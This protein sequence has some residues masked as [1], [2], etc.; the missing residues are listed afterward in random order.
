M[1]VT[2]VKGSL[3]ERL[4]RTSRWLVVSVILATSLAAITLFQH[5][6]H[7]LV[8]EI[9]IWQS[10]LITI[11]AGSLVAAVAG[12]FSLRRLGRLSELAEAERKERQQVEGELQQRAVEHRSLAAIVESSQDAII[13]EDLDGTVH[14][15]NKGAER[16][17]GWSAEE[18]IGRN[19]AL[20]VPDELAEELRDIP[21][22]VCQG[23][24][25]EPYRTVRK[26][27]DG[28]LVD[29]SLTVSPVKDE[30]GR[31]IGASAIARDITELRH[32]EDELRRSEEQHRTMVNAMLDTAADGIITMDENGAV[33]AINPAALRMFGYSAGEVLGRSINMLM[34]EP[35]RTEHDSYVRRHLETQEKRVVG[36]G[37][38]VLG[39]K[40]DGS[41]FPVELSL[42][43][44]RISERQ[45]FTGFVRDI[46]DRKRLE[47]EFLHAQ[48]ME[49]VGRLASGIAHDF[50]NML[51]GMIGCSRMAAK[52]LAPGSP[53]RE[54]VQEIG[55]EAERGVS[56]TKRL[57]TFSRKKGFSPEPIDVNAVLQQS[58]PMIRQLVGEDIE[59]E[60][61]LAPSLGPV[62]ADP[63][64]IEQVVMNLVVNARD[65]MPLGGTLRI[66]TSRFLGSGEEGPYVGRDGSH[67]TISVIDDGVGMDQETKLRAF[68][69]FFTTKEAGAGTGLGLATVYGIVKQLGGHVNLSSELG[70][71][72][73]FAI[74]LPRT[75]RAPLQVDDEVDSPAAKGGK[76]TVLVVEDE[77]LV[78]AS[79]RALLS[80]LGYRVLVAENGR[81]A[82][83][84][85]DDHEGRIDLLLSDIVMPG[86]SGPDLAR[87]IESRRP[88]VKTLYMS[89][90]PQEVLIEQGR[91][92]PGQPAIAKPFNEDTL[93]QKIRSVL[94]APRDIADADAQEPV[95]E[96]P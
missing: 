41:Q 22:K 62:L 16:L 35:Q 60:V 84:V 28:S 14:S 17:Y 74:H 81:N 20:I 24:R 89:A 52:N 66:E 78:R 86:M 83:R 4:A 88:G 27:K 79:V 57:L 23:E 39:Q 19:L 37:R 58:E 49:A 40:K 85:S 34:P 33:E 96:T 61:R 15:W 38:E 64:Q 12:Y 93:A 92:A 29:V 5:L 55:A 9:G 10:H 32:A 44:V 80:D 6:K 68:E 56:L 21:A 75:H 46:T 8:P 94:D 31:I 18:M 47:E 43:E 76:E 69:P 77:R 50:N 53:E 11:V 45:M 71:G 72:S 87:E 67:V 51:M 30:E 90:H 36:I 59:L 65:A 2:P 82:V 1:S 13:G 42:S 7:A 95:E 48:K 73:A 70:E 3:E 91:I 63:G 54:L 25:V 26:R